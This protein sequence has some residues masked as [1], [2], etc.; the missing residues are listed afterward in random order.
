MEVKRICIFE[1]VAIGR[2]RCNR[3]VVDYI[4]GLTSPGSGI[5]RIEHFIYYLLNKVIGKG[6]KVAKV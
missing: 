1:P 6:L 5:P 3:F 2:Y 4:Q